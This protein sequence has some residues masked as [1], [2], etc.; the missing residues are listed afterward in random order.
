LVGYEPAVR[1]W[2]SKKSV[3]ATRDERPSSIIP[4]HESPR[5]RH[6]PYF[7]TG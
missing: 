5:A 1:Q 4:N 3:L 6:A 7:V 2:A